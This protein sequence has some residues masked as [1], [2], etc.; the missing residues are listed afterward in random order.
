MDIKIEEIKKISDLIDD[1]LERQTLQKQR[2][3][4]NFLL[5]GTVRRSNEEVGLH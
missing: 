3:L 4:N 1:I 5:L 2:G